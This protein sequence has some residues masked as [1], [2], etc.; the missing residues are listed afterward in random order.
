MYHNFMT[1][2]RISLLRCS[3]HVHVPKPSKIL[4]QG[5][6]Y[7]VSG[8]RTY[9]LIISLLKLELFSFKMKLF[10]HV[11]KMSTY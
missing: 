10:A 8:T 7:F 1:Q 3:I 2:T 4:S 6:T 9:K 5:R 11:I